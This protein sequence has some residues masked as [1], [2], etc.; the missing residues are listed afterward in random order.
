[1]ARRKPRSKSCR[2]TWAV[3]AYPWS[4]PRNYGRCDTLKPQVDREVWVEGEPLIEVEEWEWWQRRQSGAA[5]QGKVVRVPSSGGG[6]VQYHGAARPA[7]G[8]RGAQVCAL[9]GITYR[10]LDYWARTDL[11]RPSI[12]DATGSRAASGA[13]PTATCS[14]SRSSSGCS[15]PA[16]SSSRPAR[17]SSACAATSGVDLA[18][19][20]LVLADSRSVLATSD[21]EL[22]D[23]LA[24]G[25]GVFNILPLSGVVSEL[26]AA[27]VE[28]DNRS[29][30]PTAAPTSA[31][32][33]RLPGRGRGGRAVTDV[34]AR[35]EVNPFGPG[36][37][38]RPRVRAALRPH[39]RLLRRATGST[40]RSSSPSTGTR[41]VVRPR[42]S[43]PTS[44]CPSPG[45][46]SR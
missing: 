40:S 43:G 30:S 29:R 37:A 14:S 1:M 31:S 46:S 41:P 3:D 19:A 20:Q 7:D 39:P 35:R 27:I 6:R 21:G 4:H 9:V 23:L 5:G 25:Q 10:Q 34:S 33:C 42:R 12:A 8:F 2:L 22:V 11:L 32:G 45:S 15:T 18:S 24:G 36:V 16:S 44:G 13:T 38:V 28:L 26:E 17:P